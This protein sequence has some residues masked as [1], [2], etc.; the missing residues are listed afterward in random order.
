MQTPLAQSSEQITTEHLQPF[1]LDILKMSVTEDGVDNYCWPVSNND[2]IHFSQNLMQA[3]HDIILK[4]GHDNPAVTPYKIL[5]MK[6][7]N[8]AVAIFWG[9]M[10]R[11]GFKEA[12]LSPQIPDRFRY[13]P[14][15]FN[16]K[17]PP[18]P[19]FP[20]VLKRGPN[21]NN[22]ARQFFTFAKFKR[23]LKFLRFQKGGL[24][25]DGMKVTPIT[26]K[27]L[28]DNIISTQRIPSIKTHTEYINEDIVFCRSNRWFS[29]I[30][31]DEREKARADFKSDF[32]KE[33]MNAIKGFYKDNNIKF[34]P[35]SQ[36]YLETFLFESAL[37]ISI[38][39]N[40][41][42]AS[43]ESIPKRLW[44][45]SGGN[46]WDKM[47][48]LA[49]LKNGG[50]VTGHDHG[51]G[52]GHVNN[53][54]IGMVEL[55]GCTKFISFNK[56]QAEELKKNDTSKH[57]LDG[58]LPE[59]L[60][61]QK[62][63]SGDTT[64]IFPKFLD[65]NQKIKNI[66]ILADIYDGDRGRYGLYSPDI[67]H[68]DWHIRLAKQLKN[69]GYDVTIKIHPETPIL[70]PPIFKETLGVHIETEPLE[71]IMEQADMFLFDHI[72]TTAF[73]HALSTNVPMTVVDLH[74]HPWTET[75]K[76]LITKRTSFIDAT[77][78][79]VNRPVMDWD[80]LKQAIEEAPTKCNNHEFYNYYYA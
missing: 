67:M 77:Y 40:R 28:Q 19:P 78:N 47:L 31:E 51:A 43:P 2:R 45:G 60:G 65:P 69:W 33:I 15:L 73:R 27:I 59:I 21:A 34:E 13:W 25:V 71:N 38:H 41:L 36:D 79:A 72:Y 52:L 17:T 32:I 5:C 58:K 74:G 16:K 9:D 42:L 44:T 63:N 10:L 14:Y 29:P 46:V 75:G 62:I 1:E 70:P 8:E 66:F 64:K 18:Q 68:L 6:F 57:R 12:R 56:N 48:R 37:S 20:E 24:R 26:P 7:I 23:V 3:Y 80:A 61:L 50:D 76:S 55:W 35:H 22:A 49:V 53:P 54:I 30:E 11:E 39:Y 4:M